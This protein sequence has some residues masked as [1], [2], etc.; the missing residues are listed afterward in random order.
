MI[1][2]RLTGRVPV[3]RGAP[4][5]HWGASA[6]DQVLVG[7]PSDASAREEEKGPA[8]VTIAAQN[9]RR[10]NRYRMVAAFVACQA[11]CGSSAS[12]GDRMPPHL[13]K[14]MIAGDPAT[15][16]VDAV[17]TDAETGVAS[18]LAVCFDADD[19]RV[20]VPLA[21]ALAAELRRSGARCHWAALSGSHEWR[22]RHESLG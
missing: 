22:G 2:A 20:A 21:S 7:E 4:A 6:P 16:I 18:V 9:K 1:H 13:R 8:A 12:Q 15:I 10:R 17:A 11:G 14:G 3:A 5:R 19:R